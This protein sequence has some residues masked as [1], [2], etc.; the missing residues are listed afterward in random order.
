M[1]IAFAAGVP[2]HRIEL[3]GS[4]PASPICPIAF[5]PLLRRWIVIRLGLRHFVRALSPVC[6]LALLFA[7]ALACRICN[8]SIS[9]D[10]NRWCVSVVCTVPAVAFSIATHGHVYFVDVP[11]ILYTRRF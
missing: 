10:P 1:W 11:C 3:R 7:P 5:L 2:S 9:V 6:A 8:G 4:V